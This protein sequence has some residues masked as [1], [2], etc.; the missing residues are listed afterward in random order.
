MHNAYLY[1]QFGKIVAYDTLP[2][3]EELG[4]L[5]YVRQLSS[6]NFYAVHI[7]VMCYTTY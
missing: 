4:S 7:Q 6:V 2:L 5:F 1:H 3:T